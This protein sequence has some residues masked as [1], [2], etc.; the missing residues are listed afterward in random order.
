MDMLKNTR[1]KKYLFSF[2]FLFANSVL[3]SDVEIIKVVLTKDTGTWRA[4]VTLKH[5]DTGWKHYADGWRLTD[6]KG[7]EIVKRT[8]YHPHVNEQPFTR[9]TSN[10]QIPSDKKVIFVEAHDLNRGW[11]KNKVAIDMSKSSGSKDT[12]KIR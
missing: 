5:D 10:F 7:R 2:G 6:E 12:I 11:S 9:S 4:D 8:L 1:V 3:A